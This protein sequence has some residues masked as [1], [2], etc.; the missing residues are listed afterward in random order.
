M[1]SEFSIADEPEALKTRK[2]EFYV[3]GTEA[4]EK[5]DII[6]NNETVHT[7]S[8]VGLREVQLTWE[9]R[10]GFQEIAIGP[11]E[12]C[13]N[14]FLFYYARVRQVDGEM[15]WVSPVWILDAGC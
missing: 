13:S 6:C 7:V 14:S 8:P 3:C 4:I 1:G 10:R 11:A 12:W 9:D 15:A 5:V 2:I